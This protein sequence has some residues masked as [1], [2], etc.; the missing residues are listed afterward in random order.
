MSNSVFGGG[1]KES[2]E[3][4]GQSLGESAVVK[5]LEKDDEGYYLI[6]SSADLREFANLANRNEPKAKG[7]LIRD[8]KL[9]GGSVIDDGD[10]KNKDNLEKWT[11]IGC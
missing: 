3:I 2:K 10:L 9:N 5:G 6:G 1:P 4:L 7:K 8:I 11:P